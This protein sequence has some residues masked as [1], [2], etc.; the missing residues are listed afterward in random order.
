MMTEAQFAAHTLDLLDWTLTHDIPR[1]MAAGAGDWTGTDTLRA[2]LADGSVLTFH[3][4]AQ[5]R[6]RVHAKLRAA[7][8]EGHITWESEI[9]T[10]VIA[11]SKARAMGV[12]E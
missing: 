8:P 7:T 6:S 10:S 1:R 9:P 12:A 11:A 2:T 5:G 3:T 4:V